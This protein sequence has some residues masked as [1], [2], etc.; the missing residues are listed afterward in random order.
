MKNEIRH[1]KNRKA[2]KIKVLATILLLMVMLLAAVLAAI[3]FFGKKAS[4][5]GDGQ[6]VTGTVRPSSEPIEI[7]PSPTQYVD[8]GEEAAIISK[9]SLEEK[10]AQLFF[11]TPEALTQVDGVTEAGD[12]TRQSFSELPVGGL[13]L[14]KGNI[15]SESQLTQMTE[16]LK[17]ISKDRI[18]VVPFIGVDE[19]GGSVTRIGGRSGFSAEN[20]GNMKKIG[21]TGNIVEAYEAGKIIG[22]YLSEY[23]INVNFAPVADVLVESGNIIGNRGFGSKPELVTYMAANM[24]E[25]L[26]SCGIAATLKHF[27]GYG[28]VSDDP[29]DGPVSS[30]RTLEQL[31]EC[32]FQ[33]FAYGAECGVEF[34]MTAHTSF[35]AVLNDDTPASLS[36]YLI[37]DILRKELKFDGIVITDA[38]NMGAITEKYNSSEAAVK[39]IQ[40]G[41]DMILMPEDLR[42]AYQG[43]LSAVR[44][45]EISEERID[46]SLKRILKV[47]LRMD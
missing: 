19:E 32:E 35:P 14:M 6:S 47:K 9:M 3:I 45:G 34:V 20:V 39:A 44:S 1:K 26:R 15:R 38:M 11:V 43:V 23:G 2:T 8:K 4:Q 25:T 7:M 12:I 41:C 28:S 22:T 30:D 36:E 46:E 33:P 10:I 17:Q 16:N 29:H 31:R 24:A 5:D 13:V 18:N 42:E 27:P 37:T 21:E 40:A